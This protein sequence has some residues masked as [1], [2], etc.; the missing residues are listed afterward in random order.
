MDD[1]R[2]ADG[3]D[4]DPEEYGIEEPGSHN[5]W[6]FASAADPSFPGRAWERIILSFPGSAW[7]RTAGEALPRARPGR[8]SLPSSP[9]PGGAWERG[10]RD[11]GRSLS[12]AAASAPLR[13]LAMFA[14][15][16][17]NVGAA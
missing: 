12:F 15:R 14:V 7:E 10:A 17:T 16:I 13:C 9:F 3:A 1:D 11:H 8:Q 6:S 2:G 4:A 5:C